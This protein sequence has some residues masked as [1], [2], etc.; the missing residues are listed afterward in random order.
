MSFLKALSLVTL[1]LVFINIRYILEYVLIEKQ[2]TPYHIKTSDVEKIL[3]LLA[4]CDFLP[5]V[6]LI[7]CIYIGTK[8]DWDAIMSAELHGPNEDDLTTECGSRILD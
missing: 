8:G 5:F 3:V 1:S 7:T 2:V 6:C 4:L